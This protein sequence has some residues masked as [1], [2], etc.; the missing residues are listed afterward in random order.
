MYKKIVNY[1]N[2]LS[3]G[4]VL[5][6]TGVLLLIFKRNLLLVFVYICSL[7][8]TLIG[9]SGIVNFLIKKKDKIYLF[10]SIIN[11][12]LGII[13]ILIP[14]IPL[15]IFSIIFALYILFNGAIKLIN[16]YLL[17]KNHAT[18]RL[19]VLISSLI[20]IIFSVTCMFSPLYSLNTIINI[21]AL[22]FIALSL[23]YIFDFVAQI[24]PIKSKNNFKRKIKITLPVFLTSF[25]PYT[26]LKFINKSLET[27]DTASINFHNTKSDDDI[28]MEI[29]IHVADNGFMK[30]GHVDI[31]FDNEVITYGNYDKYSLKLFTSI[32]DGVLITI[33]SKEEYIKF[34]QNDTKKTLFGFGLKLTD[35]QKAMIRKKIKDIKSNT[36]FWDG[37]STNTDTTNNSYAIRLY[38]ATKAKFYKFNSGKFKTYFVMSTNCVLLADSIIGS[39]GTDLLKINGIITPGSY[40]DYLMKEYMKK[41]SMVISYNIYK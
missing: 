27:N 8:I 10:S 32:G 28:D 2:L 37:P 5:L 33:N 13:M 16:Y 3:I 6:I 12:I 36:Y 29:F 9:V 39:L 30:M 40:Y 15:S 38:K 20:D 26:I 34:C 14:N 11:F 24:I 18:N 41:N 17:R 7:I 25:I 35:K 23:T 4:L 21:I 22:Y 19:R 31:Y 1:S